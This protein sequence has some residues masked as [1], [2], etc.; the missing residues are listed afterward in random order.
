MQQRSQLHHSRR[1]PRQCSPRE[2]PDR[3]TAVP[4]T[5]APASEMRGLCV[6]RSAQ[7]V[8][9]GWNVFLLLRCRVE[10]L[11]GGVKL[12]LNVCRVRQNHADH[13]DIALAGPSPG[14]VGEVQ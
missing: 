12:T 6:H 10:H 13:V 4:L 2:R 5:N 11:A 7:S 14:I 9:A 1:P 3:L 8:P